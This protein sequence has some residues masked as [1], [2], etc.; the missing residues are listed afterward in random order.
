MGRSEFDKTVDEVMIAFLTGLIIFM[1][2]G[3][4]Y[5]AFLGGLARCA[6]ESVLTPPN[7]L[8]IASV[9]VTATPNGKVVLR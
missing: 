6:P 8:K 4:F 7:V 9:N 1:M 3:T 2:V 5:M